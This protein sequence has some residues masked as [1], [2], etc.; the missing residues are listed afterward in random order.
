[1]DKRVQKSNESLLALIKLLND[2][3]SQPEVYVHQTCIWDALKSQGA[4]S[5]FSDDSLSIYPSSINTLKRCAENLIGGGFQAL[6]SLRI[7]A[8]VAI[9]KKRNENSQP[10]KHS[11]SGLLLANQKLESDLQTLRN[12]LLLLTLICQRSFIQGARY[13]REA[14]P[15]I[16]ARCQKEQ[17]EL[18]DSLSLRNISLSSKVAQ[19]REN[20]I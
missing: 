8:K 14:S 10:A 18:L 20:K 13:A 16:Y 3:C 11:R 19:L 5:K 1:M 2:I 15:I 9:E 4:L 12:D 7:K 17:R 6:D